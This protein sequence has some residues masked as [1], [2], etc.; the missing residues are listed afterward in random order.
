MW[1]INNKLAELWAIK[2]HRPLTN[3]E[4]KELYHC[5]EANLNKC[6]KV[7]NLKNLSLLASMNDDIDWQHEICSQLDK[8]YADLY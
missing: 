3:D 7:A 1:C 5:L 2:K 4:K 8:I 6:R